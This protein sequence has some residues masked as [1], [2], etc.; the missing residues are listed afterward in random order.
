[1]MEIGGVSRL[2]STPPPI[3]FLLLNMVQVDV[4]YKIPLVGSYN[5]GVYEC[6]HCDYSILECF[7]NHI[8]GFSES[9]IGVV[10]VVECPNCYEKYYSHASQHDYDLFLDAVKSGRNLHFR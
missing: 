8:C 3:F 5:V 7:Y 1:M 9:P 6:N 10:K 4:K 2:S